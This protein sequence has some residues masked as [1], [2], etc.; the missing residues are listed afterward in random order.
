MCICLFAEWAGSEGTE[1]CIY[2]PVGGTAIWEETV[3]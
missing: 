3:A 2:F 1:D